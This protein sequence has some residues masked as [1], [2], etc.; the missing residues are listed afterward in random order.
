MAFGG[1][2]FPVSTEYIEF[3]KLGL[4]RKLGTIQRMKV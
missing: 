3:F 4:I 2:H 1:V